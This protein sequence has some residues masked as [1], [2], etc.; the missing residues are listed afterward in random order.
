MHART[1]LG[2]ALG[3][4][5][6][7][8]GT[9]VHS[10]FCAFSNAKTYLD[11][12]PSYCHTAAQVNHHIATDCPC[13]IQGSVSATGPFSCTFQSYTA[14]GGPFGSNSDTD[15]APTALVSTYDITLACGESYKVRMSCTC[16]NRPSHT[17]FIDQGSCEAE[18]E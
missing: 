12:G 14:W 15:T 11:P 9:W 18:C 6:V 4:V 10:D 2:I 3:L 13:R 16:E 17:Y 1:R 5:V 8:T 7:L